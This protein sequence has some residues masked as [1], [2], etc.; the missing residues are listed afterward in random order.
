MYFALRHLPNSSFFPVLSALSASISPFLFADWNSRNKLRA[1][2]LEGKGCY[3][4]L[5]FIIYPRPIW[6]VVFISHFWKWWWKRKGKKRKTYSKVLGYNIN[7]LNVF[8]LMLYFEQFPL[9]LYYQPFSLPIGIIKISR[10][11]HHFFFFFFFY[12]V[13][14]KNYFSLSPPCLVCFCIHHF[15]KVCLLF[16]TTFTFFHSPFP[17][18]F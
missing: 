7:N 13:H 14:L 9:F 17:H 4:V 3:L 15:W 1:G 11:E 10:E 18:H 2:P 8:C 12:L 16:S 5:Y 6:C